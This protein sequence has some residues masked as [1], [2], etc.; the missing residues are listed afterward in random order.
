M[1]FEISE[2]DRFIIYLSEALKVGK[3][4]ISSKIVFVYTNVTSPVS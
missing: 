2:F 4:S 3:N 1:I